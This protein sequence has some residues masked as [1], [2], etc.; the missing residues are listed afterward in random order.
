MA[1]IESPFTPEQVKQ[2]NRW[3]K[4][5]VHPYTCRGHGI[6]E[7]ERNKGLSEGILTATTNYWICPCGKYTQDWAHSFMADEEYVDEVISAY[8]KFFIKK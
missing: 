2:F 8:E 7:C 1:K 4:A 6:T 3:Q 5:P